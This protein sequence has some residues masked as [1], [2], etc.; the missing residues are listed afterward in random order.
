MPASEID[1]A[2]AAGFFYVR[3]LKYLLWLPVRKNI[4]YP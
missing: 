3:H 2:A 1:P 4:V